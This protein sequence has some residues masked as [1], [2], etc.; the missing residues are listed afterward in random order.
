[1]CVC[2]DEKQL[3]VSVPG[4]SENGATLVFSPISVGDAGW[5]KCSAMYNNRTSSSYSFLLN[6]IGEL[7][8]SILLGDRKENVSLGLF[9][10]E[11]SGGLSGI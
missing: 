11:L 8:R 6:V 7:A 3:N 5:Y 2:A 4:A 9:Q 10:S 1:M